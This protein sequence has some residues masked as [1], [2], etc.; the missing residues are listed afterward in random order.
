MRPLSPDSTSR[1]LSAT[2]PDAFDFEEVVSSLDDP[3][4]K[5]HRRTVC[6]T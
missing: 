2:V 4:R 6:A 5:D 3:T 1:G